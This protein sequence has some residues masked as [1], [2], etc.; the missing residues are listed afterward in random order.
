MNLNALRT[1]HSKLEIAQEQ[2]LRTLSE[3]ALN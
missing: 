1:A 3:K 2:A